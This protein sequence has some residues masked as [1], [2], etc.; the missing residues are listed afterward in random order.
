MKHVEQLLRREIGLD[1]ASVGSALID[2]SVRRRMKELGLARVAEYLRLLQF[3]TDEWKQLVES[4]VITETWF[5]RD[6]APFS[7]FVRL[8]ET[9]WLPGHSGDV[10]RVLSVACA[11][12]E[13][14]YSLAMALLDAGWME[15]RFRIE[16]TDIS[17]RAL[18]RAE[19]GLYGRNSFRGR[20]LSFRDHHFRVTG[21]VCEL[22]AA[23]R[24]KVRFHAGNFLRED[25]VF[26]RGRYDFVFC[27]NLLMYFH[28]AA[29]KRACETLRRLLSTDGV[30]FVG[31][32]EVPLAM[33]NGFLPL[34]IPMAFACRR[35]NSKRPRAAGPVRRDDPPGKQASSRTTP[36]AALVECVVRESPAPRSASSAP[37]V[38]DLESAQRLADAGELEQATAICHAYLQQS[39][40]SAKA[41]YLL[42]LLHDACG[43][44]QAAD[45]Y[46]KTLYLDPDH[47][48]A[49]W[50]LAMLVEK[51]GDLAEAQALRRRARR[52]PPNL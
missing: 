11:S 25:R 45:W 28:R 2:H 9:E 41:Y 44:P 52:A 12:G 27:R 49:L 39:G 34:E 5:F 4:V 30:L 3:C 21:D 6:D 36:S 8:A 47:A 42:G 26:E 15:D 14:P 18:E 16:A 46:R 48:E 10:L 40:A 7:A 20:N 32:A 13:E 19:R 50:Q 17:E 51:D 23:V 1:P 22:N 38:A 24:R 31:P 43:N 37:A 29:R 35:S 33:Q